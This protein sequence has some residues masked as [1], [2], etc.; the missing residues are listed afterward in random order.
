LLLA[1]PTAWGQRL[2]IGAWQ[3]RLDQSTATLTII[4]AD[5]DGALHGT[6]YYDPPLEGFAGSPFTIKI[7]NGAFTIR[8]VNGTR[9]QD[10]HW[11]RDA[12]CG[13]FYMPDDTATPVLFERPAQ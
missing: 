13:T 3:W 9:Y 1:S 4:T 10:M 8:L 7:E 12:L 2:L 11:C 5:N 6:M